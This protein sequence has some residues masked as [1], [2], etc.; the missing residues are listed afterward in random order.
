MVETYEEFKSNYDKKHPL[1]AVLNKE[2]LLSD[3]EMHHEYYVQI[4]YNGTDVDMS[5]Y[6]EELTKHARYLVNNEL[7]CVNQVD[8]NRY[9]E[10]MLMLQKAGASK[11]E[12]E[13]V[14]SVFLTK[15][16]DFLRDELE[17]GF[18]V[19]WDTNLTFL[20]AR[21]SF[22]RDIRIGT[23][24][25][26]LHFQSTIFSNH[27]CDF[28]K[29][30]EES[31]VMF[32]KWVQQCYYYYQRRP[33]HCDA[34]YQ[35]APFIE[36]ITALCVTCCR[37]NCDFDRMSDYILFREKF[38]T[39]N[40]KKKAKKIVRKFVGIISGYGER[41][42]RLLICF[43]ILAVVFSIT[44]FFLP[45]INGLPDNV[46]DRGIASIYFYITTCLTIGYGEIHPVTSGAMLVVMLNEILGFVIGGSFIS[47][48]LRK[49]FRY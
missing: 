33:E 23:T 35:Y 44:Y 1:A 15:V 20:I 3:F 9:H 45:G 4:L 10:C 28:N 13:N 7:V 16:L 37:N 49:I 17:Y 27:R 38:K 18:S 12:L 41:P 29:V 39:Q 2:D 26:E 43:G 14:D 8:Y 25:R 22:Y 19:F 46:F 5:G 30:I 11:E 36:E 21:E 6:K 40:E 42:L 34:E 31:Y 24:E 48:Y 32:L 47:L